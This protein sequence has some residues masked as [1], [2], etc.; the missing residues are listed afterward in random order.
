M[1]E[2][3]CKTPNISI[4]LENLK[5]ALHHLNSAHRELCFSEKGSP[6]YTIE[7]K[8]LAKEFDRIDELVKHITRL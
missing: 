3:I 6:D 1:A 8:T 7:R 5:D 2:A 4:V